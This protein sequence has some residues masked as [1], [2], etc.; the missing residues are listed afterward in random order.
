MKKLRNCF[1]GLL[2]S[3][4]TIIGSVSN[5]YASTD[6]LSTY[7]SQVINMANTYV[8]SS[9]TYGNA[10]LNP[11]IKSNGGRYFTVNEIE[12]DHFDVN[13]NGVPITVIISQN[14]SVEQYKPQNVTDLDDN[15]IINIIESS[16]KKVDDYIET[17]SILIDK[18]N[19]ENYINSLSI[20][21]A[22]FT[23]DPNVGAYF[24]ASDSIIYVNRENSEY[25]CEWLVCHEY[26]H[27]VS[28]YTHKETDLDNTQYAY[29][30]YNEVLTDLLTCSLDPEINGSI[31]SY[32]K[33]YYAL[34]YPYINIFDIDAIDAYFYGYNTIYSKVTKPEF[35]FFVTVIEN[36]NEQNSE[37]YYNNLVLKWYA[38]NLA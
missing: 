6:I 9:T 34:I 22:D 30:L 16:R 10:D 23:D 33:G 19:I 5:V 3:V 27:A 1:C 25:I 32:Y 7:D 31:E 11:F 28:F 24:S 37:A 38:K 18:D 35:D 26:M 14:N 8:D 2:V 15:S 13:V 12:T 36:I 29:S 4:L 21:A 20:K 17:S